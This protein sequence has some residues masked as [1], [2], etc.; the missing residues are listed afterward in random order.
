MCFSDLYHLK[1]EKQNIH[2]SFPVLSIRWVYFL[3]TWNKLTILSMKVY[4]IFYHKRNFGNLS[5]INHQWY[6]LHFL[7]LYYV[8][9]HLNWNWMSIFWRYQQN[10]KDMSHYLSA[11]FLWYHVN[12]SFETFSGIQIR[13]R[14][15]KPSGWKRL[16]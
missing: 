13:L 14:P 2:D 12:F 16:K 11:F 15:E 7:L 5:K 9:L 6:G 10:A 4:L 1:R 3:L 8:F